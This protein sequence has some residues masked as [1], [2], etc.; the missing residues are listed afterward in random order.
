MTGIDR[1]IVRQLTVA[2]IAVTGGLALLIWLTQS[3]RFVE[4]VVNRGL[5]FAVFLQLTSMMIPSFVVVILPITTFVVVLF[6]YQRLASDRELVVMRAAGVSPGRLSRPALTLATIAALCGW[7]LHAY[8]VPWSYGQFR[9]FQFEIRNRMAAVLLQDGVFT[10]VSD[11]VTVYVRE[12]RADGTLRGLV[13]HDARD[14]ANPATILAEAGTITS[15]PTGPRVTLFNGS[16]QQLDRRSGRLNVLQFSENTLDL[17]QSRQME[18][19]RA[20]DSR[21]RSVRELL[22]PDPN[23]AI[24]PRDIPK[25]RVE[26]HQRLSGPLTGISFTLVALAATLTG[27]FRRHGGLLRPLIGIGLLVGLLALGLAIGN[28]AARVPMMI[29]LIW[30]HALA[31]G[32]IAALMLFGPRAALPAWARA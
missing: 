32:M 11:D 12:R 26:A 5:S 28:L 18:E 17:A 25:F 15:G 21:E 29:P 4:L 6:V 23:E 22:N 7:L 19:N 14:Q 31:P 2:L 10:P 30:V 16:R 27:T 8:V 9:E 3:L 24:N 13:I 20:R 1:Y